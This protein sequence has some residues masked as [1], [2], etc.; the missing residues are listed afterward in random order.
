MSMTWVTPSLLRPGVSAFSAFPVGAP[1]GDAPVD[2][3]RDGS[4]P[5]LR[6]DRVR[7]PRK[8]AEV[9]E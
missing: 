7:F 9:R 5:S 8:A 4:Q 6:G 1:S 3:L 2:V